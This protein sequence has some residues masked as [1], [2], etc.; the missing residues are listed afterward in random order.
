M[1][2]DFW[3]ERWLRDEIGF[4]QQAFNTHLQEFWRSLGLPSDAGVFVPLC[5]KTLD[6][7]RSM[8]DFGKKV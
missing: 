6:L 3:H 2:H 8:R 5:G 4:H 7:L 1:K